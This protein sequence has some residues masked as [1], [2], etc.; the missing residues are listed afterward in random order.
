M[1]GPTES[2]QAA[3]FAPAR[4]SL[5]ALPLLVLGARPV[6]VPPSSRSSSGAT[7]AA[8]AAGVSSVQTTIWVR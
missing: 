2:S 7:P 4:T 3:M 1:P 6:E 5:Q 8:A